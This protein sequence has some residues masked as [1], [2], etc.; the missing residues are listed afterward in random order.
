MPFN[1]IPKYVTTSLDHDDY[2]YININIYT[3]HMSTKIQFTHLTN[4]KN[5]VAK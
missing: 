4:A 5:C 3:Y 2:C 1:E